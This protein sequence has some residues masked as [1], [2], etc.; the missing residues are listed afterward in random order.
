MTL[1][2]PDPEK[3]LCLFTDASEPYWA[4]VLTQVP[5]EEFRSNRIPQERSHVPIGLVSGS[6]KSSSFRWTV[7]EKDSYAIIASVIRLRHV[8]VTCGE[9]SIFTDRKNILYVMSPN[10]F[11][12]NVAR[13]VAHKVQR[14]AIKLS[15]F[16]FTVEHIS[17]KSN[18]WAD[19]LM[20]WAEPDY[21]NFQ[22]GESVLSKPRW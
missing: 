2:I 1:S 13:S 21:S 20:R 6:F 11:Q 4:G 10:R 5:M 7:P 12:S 14:W 22:Q 9:F 15:E 18:I 3:R 17:G 16:N 19:I 8:L